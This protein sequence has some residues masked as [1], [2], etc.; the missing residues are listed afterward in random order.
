[1]SYLGLLNE[2]LSRGHGL[3]CPIK[4][5]FV[6]MSYLGLLNEDPA[7]GHSLAEP[8]LAP[9]PALGHQSRLLYAIICKCLKYFISI[10]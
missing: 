6:K 10:H 2:D 4:L 3:V 1:M 8:N 7:R 9:F 5:K